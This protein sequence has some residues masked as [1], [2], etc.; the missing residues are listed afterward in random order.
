MS[1]PRT[2]SFQRTVYVSDLGSVKDRE[3][4]LIEA[5]RHPI[6]PAL[7]MEEHVSDLGSVKAERV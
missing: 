2:L 5:H 4:L 6:Q 1:L 7:A 3:Y